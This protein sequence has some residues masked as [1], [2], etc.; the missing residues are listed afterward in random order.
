MNGILLPPCRQKKT[1]Y[2]FSNML[3]IKN[4]FIPKKESFYE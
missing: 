4:P 1:V 2:Y 3:Y